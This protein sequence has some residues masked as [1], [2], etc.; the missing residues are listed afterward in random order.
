MPRK[1]ITTT[2]FLAAAI[3]MVALTAAQPVEAGS[4]TVK[5][6]TNNETAR[7]V[8]TGLQLY[9]LYRN[10]KNRAKVTQR[11]SGNGAAISQ[12]GSGNA[13]TVYQRGRGHSA[14]VEQ[15]GSGNSIGVFQFG[16]NTQYSSRQTGSNSNVLVFQGGW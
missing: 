1:Q 16:K 15:A 12:T 5:V 9:S 13:A 14:T 3:S 8:G 4:M 2:A 11:G 6:K 10:E 7:L